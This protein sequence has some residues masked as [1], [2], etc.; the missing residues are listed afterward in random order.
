MQGRASASLS[1]CAIYFSRLGDIYRGYLPR[2]R[3]HVYI[4]RLGGM[5]L[6]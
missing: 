5:I 3:Q 4:V 2:R 6:S 1:S